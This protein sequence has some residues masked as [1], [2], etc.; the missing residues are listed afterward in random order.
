MQSRSVEHEH[1]D[2][3]GVHRKIPG[4]SWWQ[5]CPSGQLLPSVEHEIGPPVV[6]S[7]P[8]LVLVPSLVVLALDVLDVVAVT[9]A[10]V[11]VEPP[12]LV[13]VSVAAPP[14][15][16]TFDVAGPHALEPS[17]QIS[18]STALPPFMPP[19]RRTR[20]TAAKAVGTVSWTAVAPHGM[21]HRECSTNA[22]ST[23]R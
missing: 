4:T 20:A 6:L 15:V 18:E 10:L 17:T 22:P 11:V 14:S 12:V 3:K 8:A 7:A 1:E 23:R 9:L 5:H 13:L 19:H 16:V 21:L 2:P